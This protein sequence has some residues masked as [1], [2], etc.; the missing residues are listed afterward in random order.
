MAGRS[1]CRGAVSVSCWGRLAMTFG[2]PESGQCVFDPG[3]RH[4]RPL[5]I[6]GVREQHEVAKLTV[7]IADVVAQEPFGGEPERREHRHGALLL[8]DDLDVELAELELERLQQRPARE[9]APDA[10]AAVF[11]VDD[12]AHLAD[13]VRPAGQGHDRDVAG[14]PA[15][16]AR[17]RAPAAAGGP[18]LDDRA[19][20][21]GLLEEGALGGRDAFEEGEQGVDVVGAGAADLH[22]AASECSAI[23][24]AMPGS[25]TLAAARPA[26][27]PTCPAPSRSSSVCSISWASGS[28]AASGT[29]WSRS[30]IT[31]RTGTSIA[32]RSASEPSI[33]PFSRTR[34]CTV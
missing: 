24:P 3:A 4:R 11:G 29:M 5:I 1:P 21:H 34:R 22:H 28:A 7:P 32:A 9:R 20:E 26:T 19:I 25:V 30:A 14:D 10:L 31:F 23:Q 6:D 12:Q 16:L 18:R 33:S 13:G 15:V 17:E 27:R 8:G 2:Y